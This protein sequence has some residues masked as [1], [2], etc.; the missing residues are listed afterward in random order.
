VTRQQ[1]GNPNGVVAAS[2]GGVN[3]PTNLNGNT[4]TDPTAGLDMD[5]LDTVATMRA[6]L[7]A[8]SGTT[9]SAAQLDKMTFNDMVY[10][11]R[12]ND[13]ATSIKQ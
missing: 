2:I 1:I 9:Y 5:N 3:N 7:T 6:R 8:I 12:L 4:G 13:F 10:A 11:I